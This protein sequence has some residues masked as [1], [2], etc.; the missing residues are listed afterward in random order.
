MSVT[1]RAAAASRRIVTSADAF[2]A[3]AAATI[4]RVLERAVADRGVASLALAGGTT[5]EPV[6]RKLAT[7]ATLHWNQIDIYFGDERAVPP[8]SP[9]SNYNRAVHA[10]LSPLRTA[11]RHTYRMPAEEP[12]LDAAARAYAA[13]LPAQLD[14]IV[15]GIGEDGHMA[16]LFPGSPA[17]META[18]TVVAVHGPKPPHDRLTLTPLAIQAARNVIVLAAG[19]P[20]AAAVAQALTG[21]FAPHHCPAQLVREATW[22]ID[23][24]AAAQLDREDRE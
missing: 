12:D 24:A 21:P 11:P 22:V 20:K 16:S 13:L 3:T 14:L 7:L 17:L 6:Y 15:L 4:A 8:E 10:L 18:R 9:D 19:A 1:P 5:P 23:T 2:A